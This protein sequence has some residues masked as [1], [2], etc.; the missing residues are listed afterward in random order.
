MNETK[1]EKARNL[2]HNIAVTEEQIRKLD[3]NISLIKYDDSTDL[4]VHPRRYCNIKF[5]INLPTQAVIDHLTELKDQHI[6]KLESFKKE[7][8]ML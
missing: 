8:E 7:F 5:V 2:I 1:F 4:T 6:I 3:T